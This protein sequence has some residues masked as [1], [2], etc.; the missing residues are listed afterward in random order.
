M[1]DNNKNPFPKNPVDAYR[2]T[3]VMTA[4]RETIL[5]MM[6]AGAIRFLKQAIAAAEK[7]D[8]TEKARMVSKT[9]DIV[10]EL[11]ATLNFEV[12]GDIARNL[13]MLY[14]FITDRLMQANIEKKIEYLHEALGILV[15]LNDAWEGAVA[16]LRKEKNQQKPG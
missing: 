4:N 5:L 3:D 9:Q 8:V 15:T 11:R 13:E 10:N 1:P 7:N 16:N 2:R 12:G 6:Y 14:G